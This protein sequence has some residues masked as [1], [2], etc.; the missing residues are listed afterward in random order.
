MQQGETAIERFACEYTSQERYQDFLRRHDGLRVV[1]L[2]LGVG[3][4]TPVIIKYPFRM[5]TL[6]N[7]NALCIC[8][9]FQEAFAPKEIISRSICINSDIGGFL[10]NIR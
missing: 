5:Y 2:E 6:N 1:F 10:Q 8:V 7:P 4:N 9:N 3:G